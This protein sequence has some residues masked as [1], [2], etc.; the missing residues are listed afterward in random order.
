M[1]Q[2]LPALR[3]GRRAVFLDRDGTLV[4]DVPY[5][6]E[7]RGLRL[8]RGAAAAV[9]RLR[10]AGF[11]VVL[12]TNQ[13]GVGRG[14][15]DPDTLTAIHGELRRR[16]LRHGTELDGIYV[17]PHRPGE[18]CGCR[19]PAKGLLHRAVRELGLEVEGSFVVG[20]RESD[21]ALAAGTPL[22]AILLR[23]RGRRPRGGTAADHVTSSLARAADWILAQRPQGNRRMSRGPNQRTSHTGAAAQRRRTRS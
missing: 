4:R 22:K 23:P 3:P 5:L 7:P 1:T 14:R 13:S 10:E 11:A 8:L 19:K 15:I 17:C 21:V 2:P 16:L 20:D 9:R 12:L 6:A 18:G